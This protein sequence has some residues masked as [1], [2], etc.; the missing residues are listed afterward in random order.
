MK[1]SAV[2]L[3]TQVVGTIISFFSRRVFLQSLGVEYLG[4][5]TI[6]SQ[7]IGTLSITELGIHTV[8]VYKLYK[9]VVENDRNKVC[10]I[11][12]V[13]RSL[14]RWIAFIILIGGALLFPFLKFIITDIYIP[15]HE[16]YAFWIIMTITSAISYLLSYN[17]ALL[18]AD[19]RQYVFTGINGVVN[20]IFSL[21][22]IWMLLK[23]SNMYIYLAI[24]MLR[25]ITSNVMILTD[26]KKRYSWVTLKKQ[27][28]ESYMDIIRN[29]KDVFAGRLAGYVFNST[30]SIVISS[31]IS[32]AA[33]GVVG[34]YTIII[35]SLQALIYSIIGPIQ[36]LAGNYLVSER[37]R[38]VDI[39]LL[40]YT[41][42]TYA[43]FSVFFVPT[44]ALIDDFITIFLGKQY[45]LNSGLKIILLINIYTTLGQT[46]VGNMVDAAGLFNQE[47]KMYYISAI[48]N[49]VCS[50]LGAVTMGV[51][52]VILG[53]IIG[54]IYTWIKRTHLTYI[55]VMD[56][57][58]QGVKRYFLRNV[59]YFM[60]F[61]LQCIA[62]DFIFSVFLSEVSI[63]L[64]IIK[65]VISV[66][67]VGCIHYLIFSRRNEFKYMVGFIK[68]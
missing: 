53:T 51:E 14:Y 37:N 21:I 18:Y 43:L 1:N 66:V 47:K 10:E 23:F 40:N 20:I 16:I 36:S 7:L 11:I 64:F 4:L 22:N 12:S 48:I 30:D 2:G 50:I 68:K 42:I 44:S 32:T 38:K 49:I 28:I 56:V 52:G 24:N 33:V 19:Q 39:F 13:F 46:T 55:N 25:V 63:V 61:I 26:R 8:V 58:T 6:L 57:N 54:E 17:M 41:Y 67:F 29:T 27:K 59:F 65:S 34:N 3:M 31:L 9:P 62:L 5:N 35:S 60:L 45:L 15:M